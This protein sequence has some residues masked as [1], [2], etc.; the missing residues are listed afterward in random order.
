MYQVCYWTD[1]SVTRPNEPL[2]V[3]LPYV[4]HYRTCVTTVRVSLPYVCHYL[5]PVYH[6]A[7]LP[8]RL[9]VSL[10]VCLSV[11]P[12]LRPSVPPSVCVHSD[13]QTQIP[14]TNR[15]ANTAHAYA[16]S[17]KY[18]QVHAHTRTR[19]YVQTYTVT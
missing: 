13:T 5:N 18:M 2:C 1:S 8:A 3:S 12:S 4:C 19:M 17:R 16:H 7:Y 15:C 6:S 14:P 9:F 11:R 10:C